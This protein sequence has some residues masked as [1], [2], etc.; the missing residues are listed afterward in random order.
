MRERERIRERDKVREREGLFKGLLFRLK[1]Q[2]RSIHFFLADRTWL[3]SDFLKNRSNEY[4]SFS[5]FRTLE[6]EL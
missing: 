3:N 6:T 2:R 4:L 1:L 5:Q